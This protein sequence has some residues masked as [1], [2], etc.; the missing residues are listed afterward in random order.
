MKPQK[1]ETLLT[2][3]VKEHGTFLATR[4]KGADARRVLEEQLAAAAP[5][6]VLTIDFAGVEAMTNS[7]VDEFLGKFYLLLA[8]GDVNT[9]GVRLVGLDEETREGVTVC[10]ERRKQI[11]L[12]GDTHELL[13][14]AAILAGAYAEARRLRGFRA[15]QLAE[16][17]G[18]SLP[19][20]NNRLKRLVEAGA[21]YRERAAGPERG[22]K[23]FTYRVPRAAD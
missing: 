3:P 23:E 10:L 5:V 12:D 8:A 17:L 6:A 4:A 14:D 19:N 1:R 18:I 20:A 2:Y 9:D 22:G 7:F 16:A 21:L 11:A 13:G 15:A